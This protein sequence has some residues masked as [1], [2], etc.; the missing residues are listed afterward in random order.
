MKC[1]LHVFS[2][3]CVAIRIWALKNFRVRSHNINPEPTHFLFLWHLT[4]FV[5]KTAGSKNAESRF[6]VCGVAVGIYYRTVKEVISWTLFL[7]LDG[8]W[9][10]RGILLAIGKHGLFISTHST[11]VP[12]PWHWYG[13]KF[14]SADRTSDLFFSVNFKTPTKFF[15]FFSF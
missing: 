4:W 12:D 7:T 10:K 14:W 3:R 2:C 1:K 6:P 5:L 13:S 11:S 15:F 8:H 9:G